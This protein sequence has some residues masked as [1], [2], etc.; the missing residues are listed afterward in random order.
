MVKIKK[1]ASY[2]TVYL[3]VNIYHKIDKSAGIKFLKLP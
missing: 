1:I 2:C 3:L